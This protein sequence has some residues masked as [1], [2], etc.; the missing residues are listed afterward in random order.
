MSLTRL[1]AEAKARM[2]AKFGGGGGGGISSSGGGGGGG[3]MT[4]RESS[5]AQASA[6]LE[7]LAYDLVLPGRY[8]LAAII[9]PVDPPRLAEPAQAGSP[10]LARWGYPLPFRIR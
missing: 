9:A 8:D 7:P 6:A 5:P 4:P 10:G 1:Q 3:S 2:A